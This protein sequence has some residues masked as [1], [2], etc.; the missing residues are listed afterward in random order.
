MSEDRSHG[1]YRFTQLTTSKI[2]PSSP[3]RLPGLKA[4]ALYRV[5]PLSVSEDITQIGNAQSDSAWWNA[6]GVVLP[7]ELLMSSGLRT[8]SLHP[9]Q[10]VL[11]EAELV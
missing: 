7:G 11:F 1:V 3:V 4:D 9:A 8:P 2:Y 5:K 6:D 10:A